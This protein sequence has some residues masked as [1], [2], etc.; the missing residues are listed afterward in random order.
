M[1]TNL[2][3]IFRWGNY[4]RVSKFCVLN[5]T[6]F[7]KKGET[8]QGGDIIEGRNYGNTVFIFALYSGLKGNAIIIYVQIVLNTVA[9]NFLI[10][11]SID[12]IVL[13]TSVCKT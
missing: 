13:P 3:D 10:L 1:E 8:I 7:W 12:V 4:W 11:L 5:L 6:I 9:Q 2:F